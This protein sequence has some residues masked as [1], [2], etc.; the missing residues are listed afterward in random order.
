MICGRRVSGTNREAAGD[1]EDETDPSIH[2][3]S[4]DRKK[5]IE[6]PSS[7]IG[8]PSYEAVKR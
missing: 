1:D 2:V 3:A 6:M 4:P 8:V 7:S 5:S